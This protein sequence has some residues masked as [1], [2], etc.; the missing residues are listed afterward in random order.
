MRRKTEGKK[1]DENVPAGSCFVVNPE[2]RSS[3]RL[4]S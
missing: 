3:S 2:R 4:G 1:E